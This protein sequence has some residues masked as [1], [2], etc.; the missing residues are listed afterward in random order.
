MTTTNTNHLQE[1][2]L[3]RSVNDLEKGMFVRVESQCVSH[4][5]IGTYIHRKKTMAVVK[6]SRGDTQNFNPKNL[7]IMQV[8]R[9]SPAAQPQSMTDSFSA[10]NVHRNRAQT[11]ARPIPPLIN[12]DRIT[13][14][15]R[16]APVPAPV[17]VKSESVDRNSATS[18]K[19]RDDIFKKENEETNN[20]LSDAIEFMANQLRRRDLTAAGVDL[21][22]RVEKKIRKLDD[23]SI[24]KKK[25]Q[26]KLK[27]DE[28]DDDNDDIDKIYE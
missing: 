13:N 20:A 8:R 10:G 24:E 28:E 22:E 21:E 16:P 7:M 15:P 2:R 19:Y 14:L 5:R 18:R 12:L 3:A 25:M 26:G 23:D 27:T 17:A 4:G 1:V 9:V 6:F 11:V